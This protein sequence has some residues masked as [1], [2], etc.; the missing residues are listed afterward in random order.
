V[1]SDWP[2]PQTRSDTFVQHVDLS[3][4][5]S[6]LQHFGIRNIPSCLNGMVL[7]RPSSSHVIFNLMRMAGVVYREK[8]ANILSEFIQVYG[9]GAQKMP[10]DLADKLPFAVLECP[11]TLLFVE[12]ARVFAAKLFSED[13]IIAQCV[14]ARF[15]ASGD[16]LNL[17]SLLPSKN[18]WC[19]LCDEMKFKIGSIEANKHLWFWFRL[20]LL[21]SDYIEYMDACESSLECCWKNLSR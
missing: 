10:A 18:E 3:Y 9:R 14:G 6:F 16:L 15:P 8:I 2:M 4:D 1:S 19:K 20:R 21:F 13:D 17:A 5:P 12:S 11:R 7:T